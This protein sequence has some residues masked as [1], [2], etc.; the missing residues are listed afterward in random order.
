MSLG[1][2]ERWREKTTHL[3]SCSQAGSSWYG[4]QLPVHWG[5]SVVAVFQLC[6]Y[7]VIV[8]WLILLQKTGPSLA[9]VCRDLCGEDWG[10]YLAAKHKPSDPACLLAKL[11]A[12]GRQDQ[13]P[14]VTKQMETSNILSNGGFSFLS[15]KSALLVSVRSSSLG[16]LWASIYLMASEQGLAY[17][18]ADECPG[19][20]RLHVCLEAFPG[21]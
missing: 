17:V 15:D 19:I 13:K 1:C 20:R 3:D 7:K 18:N 16:D 12:A 14:P 8:L 9:T 6:S 11:A 2:G 5:G 10:L 4:Q 21:L